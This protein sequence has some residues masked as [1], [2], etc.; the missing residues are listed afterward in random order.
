MLDAIIN[1][2]GIGKYMKKYE[3]K[4]VINN[5]SVVYNTVTKT[6]T[7]GYS[8]DGKT[9]TPNFHITELE[10]YDLEIAVLI[11]QALSSLYGTIDSSFEKLI[12][13]YLII[14]C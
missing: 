10:E 1:P 2:K 11:C 7:A 5:C 12:N 13:E 3:K 8:I 4:L 14:Y 9:F 6:M